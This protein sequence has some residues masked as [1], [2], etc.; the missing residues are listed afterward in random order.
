MILG[1]LLAWSAQI[2]LLVAIAAAAVAALRLGSARA[3]LFFWQAALL[4]CLASP[5]TRPWKQDAPGGLV[6]FT[7]GDPRTASTSSRPALPLM[8]IALGLIAAGMM[9]RSVWMA[10]GFRRLR[11]YRLRSRPFDIRDG[12]DIRLSP[13][14]NGPVTFGALRP[15]ILLPA[16]FPELPGDTREAI[17]CHELRHVHRRDWLFTVAEESVRTA[18]W[19]HP[20]VWWLLGQIQLAREQ[21]VD[22]EVIARTGSRERY[23]DALLAIAGAKTQPDLAPAPLFLRKRHLKQRVVSIL[24]EVPMSKTRLTSSLAAG[25]G[26]L[27]AACWLLTATF[28]LTA[29]PDDKGDGKQ[30]A[31]QAESAKQIRVG[32]NKQQLKL[33]SQARP[34]YPPEAKQERIQGVVQLEVTIARDGKVKNVDVTSGHSLLVPA[35]VEAVRQWVYETTLLNGEPVE[36]IT[37]VDINFTLTK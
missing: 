9:A 12:V 16:C 10:E 34:A 36:V 31:A 27:A 15:V 30:S 37:Q 1:N 26:I 21:T 5:V 35:A 24:K 28:P 11:Q 22:R 3:R 23:V 8:E 29:A 6:S 13:D 7:S 18:L 19:F 14:L 17:L 32:G 4:T 25:L 33:V 2:A 20:A